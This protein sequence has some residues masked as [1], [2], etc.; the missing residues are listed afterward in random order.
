[1]VNKERILMI[2]FHTW[3][4]I[5]GNLS[6]ENNIEIISKY[7]EKLSYKENINLI[8]ENGCCCLQITTFANRKNE[9]IREIFNFIEKSLEIA[10]ESYGLIYMFDDE[11]LLHFN[12][13]QVYKIIRGKIIK[14][15][16]N[17][18]SPYIPTI[19]GGFIKRHQQV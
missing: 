8:T 13:F 14:D 4:N 7:I 12:E 2:E 19:S 16:D 18:L 9:Y 11:D 15:V 10:T 17:F 6:I 1:M 5:Q 3:V